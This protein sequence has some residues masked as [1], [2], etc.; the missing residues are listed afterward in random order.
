MTPNGCR[1]A[2]A[3]LDLDTGRASAVFGKSTRSVRRWLLIGPPPHIELAL[4]Q[5]LDGRMAVD[6]RVAKAFVT[7]CRSRR[8]DW[9]RRR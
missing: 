7:R 4:F 8:D 1:V 5:M 6:G 2:F 3:A 9:R